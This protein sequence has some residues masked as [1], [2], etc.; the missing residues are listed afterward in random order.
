M[1]ESQLQILVR[2]NKW[3][4]VVHKS[5]VSNSKSQIRMPYPSLYNRKTKDIT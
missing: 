2:N 1:G 5:Q 4:D 3:Q